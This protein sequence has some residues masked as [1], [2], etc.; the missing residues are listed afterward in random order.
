[1]LAGNQIPSIYPGN[2]SNFAPRFGFSYMAA[3]KMV[4]RGTYGIFFDA[5]NF[6]G[7]FDNR[8]GNGGASGVQANYTGPTPVRNVSPAFYQWQTG[9]NPFT[10]SSGAPS[11]YG[12]A[13]VDPNFRTAYVQ[14]FNTNIEY[15]VSR[16][17]LLTVGYVGSLGRR[18]FN[19]IDINQARPG[20]GNSTAVL[21]PRRPYYNNTAIANR[22]IIA[23]INQIES[24]GSSNYNSFQASLRTSAFHGLT[25]QGSY[26]YGH[27]LDVVSGTRGFAPQDSANLAGEYGNSDFDVRHTFNG[28]AVYEAPQIGHSLPGAHQGLAG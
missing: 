5:I 1:M 14:N 22:T 17:T 24:E 6:N 9:V 19:L 25:A 18:L 23:A 28:Y 3:P 8:P 10:G 27:A 12:L 13:T 21:Q 20:I 2:K 26:T 4:I 7:F 16:N 11:V 15:Q